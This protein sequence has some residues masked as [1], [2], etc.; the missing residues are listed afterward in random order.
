MICAHPPRH[1]NIVEHGRPR[2]LFSREKPQKRD[3]TNWKIY[4]S[5]LKNQTGRP[6]SAPCGGPHRVLLPFLAED[7]VLLYHRRKYFTSPEGVQSLRSPN[8]RPVQNTRE[9]LPDAIAI[10]G[11]FRPNTSEIRLNTPIL[12]TIHDILIADK[13]RTKD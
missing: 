11:L 13:I 4:E 10:R 2:N 5:L 9:P 8:R 6:Y 1:R 12:L 7:L 3:I